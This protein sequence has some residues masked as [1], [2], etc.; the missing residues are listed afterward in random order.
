[1]SPKATASRSVLTAWLHAVGE[2]QAIGALIYKDRLGSGRLWQFGALGAAAMAWVAVLTGFSPDSPATDAV[3]GIITG[4]VV[5][6]STGLG[7]KLMDIDQG[8]RSLVLLRALP[9]S[10]RT[11]IWAKCENWWRTLSPLLVSA[12]AADAWLG[13]S[14]AWRLLT[15]TALG[16]LFF[17]W[18]LWLT[19]VL[20]N[21]ILV[22][23]LWLA[24]VYAL[25]LWFGWEAAHSELLHG[26]RWWLLGAGFAIWIAGL[27]ATAR[28]MATR[29]VEL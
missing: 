22:G 7:Q 23:G 27:E 10:E 2:R 13:L 15:L 18:T 4:A 6:L 25:P 12:A 1:M 8:S 20:R 26:Q 28:R 16:L 11:V 17:S 5:I 21:P 14:L 19:A 9:C 24:P 29:E 3:Q